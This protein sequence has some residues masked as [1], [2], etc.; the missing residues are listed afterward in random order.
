MRQ[1][2]VFAT[3][4]I[5][6]VCM[7]LMG[8]WL[9]PAFGATLLFEEFS[10]S[11]TIIWEGINLAN[12]VGA[13]DNLNQWLGDHWSIQSS[14]GNYFAQENAPQLSDFTNMMYYGVS[15]SSILAGTSLTLDFKYDIADRQGKVYVAGLNYGV[16]NLQKWPSF[17]DTPGDGVVIQNLTLLADFPP[18]AGWQNAHYSFTLP[19][20]YNVLVVG[21][22]MGG[23][24][25]FRAI[26]D[27]NFQSAP[28]PEP[29][30]MLLLGLG[31]IGLVGVRRKYKQ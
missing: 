14:A 11:T 20:A 24:T 5:G 27:V 21:F 31:L 2:R 25:G 9:Q 12:G 1:R 22:E 26:D 3:I 16:H 19:L 23:S 10:A 30:T 6:L 17:F 13:D 28:V 4:K 29:T 7:G 15:A 8:F 18:N